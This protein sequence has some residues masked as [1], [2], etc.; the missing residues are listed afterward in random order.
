MYD[1]LMQ[2]LGTFGAAGADI[3][4]TNATNKA[5]KENAQAVMDF[6]ERMS[7]SAYQRATADMRKAGLN[8]MLAFSQGGANVPAGALAQAAKA[9][10]GDIV[11]R[12]LSNATQAKAVDNQLKQIESQVGVNNTQ[13]EKNKQDEKTSAAQEQNIKTNSAKTAVETQVLSKELPR[14][15]ARSDIEGTLYNF[16]KKFFNS[17]YSSGQVEDAAKGKFK[18]P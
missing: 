17:P 9:N 4:T 5:N 10:T 15:K 12:G 13:A 7:N 14:A 8:P 3:L 1:L 2:G 18:Q 6:Q 11:S 16:I